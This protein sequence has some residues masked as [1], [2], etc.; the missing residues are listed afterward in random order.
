MCNYIGQ[1][2]TLPFPVVLVKTGYDLLFNQLRHTFVDAQW[3][4]LQLVKGHS[5]PL[6]KGMYPFN[7]HGPF[8]CF[9]PLF[10]IPTPFN[11][12]F[13]T[14]PPTSPLIVNTLTSPKSLH[15]RYLFPATKRN[16]LNVDDINQ[17]LIY[18]LFSDLLTIRQTTGV[19]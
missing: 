7:T 10:V 16:H 15:W 5:F 1:S 12:T 9:P 13:Y 19:C 14:V 18:L 11:K 3:W 8:F 2:C 4:W 17:T 6:F